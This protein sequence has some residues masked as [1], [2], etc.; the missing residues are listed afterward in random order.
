[1]CGI[2]G[3]FAYHSAA[4]PPE[5]RELLRTRDAIAGAARTAAAPGGPRTGAA[6]PGHRRLAILDLSSRAA[7]P[8]ASADGAAGRDSTAKSIISSS[9]AAGWRPRVCAS[10]RAATP[11]WCCTSTQPRAGHGPRLRGMYALA[12]WDDGGE[13]FLARD[14][15]GSS[16]S[17]P[18]DGWAFRFASQV[19]ALLAGGGS[20]AIP[21]RPVSPG[22][23]C[24]APCPSRLRFIARSARCRR[25]TRR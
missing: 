15:W 5:R 21:N 17:I 23:I 22:S 19:K 2:N 25:A 9:C 6:A 12:I 7:Q 13:L 10:A 18:H 24:S 11:R 3:I 14:P 20:P 1:M 4:A 8:M 16:P